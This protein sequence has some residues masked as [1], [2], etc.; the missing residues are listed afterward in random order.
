MNGEDSNDIADRITDRGKLFLTNTGYT[1]SE[2]LDAAK[3]GSALQMCNKCS[4]KAMI[5]G[6]TSSSSVTT[7][8]RTKYE[9]FMEDYVVPLKLNRDLFPVRASSVTE[10]TAMSNKQDLLDC[11][12]G[13][14]QDQLEILQ[15]S[16]F[17]EDDDIFLAAKRALISQHATEVSKIEQVFGGHTVESMF[18][19]T[20]GDASNEVRLAEV[21][22]A[23]MALSIDVELGAILVKHDYQQEP[24]MSPPKPKRNSRL[25]PSPNR[26]PPMI[27]FCYQK[28]LG[29]AYVNY[30]TESWVCK[31]VT[32]TQD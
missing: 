14:Y 30:S 31:F 2:L 12:A 28:V 1:A 11:L 8:W 25:Q 7:L 27:L 13:R 16:P 4:R 20:S 26:V 21:S 32:T 23:A 5:T 10:S 18:A 6:E 17:F 15:S 24:V 29:C 22:R 3:P 19:F 9:T